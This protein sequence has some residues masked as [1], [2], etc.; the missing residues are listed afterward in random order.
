[1]EQ[2]Q[3]RKGTKQASPKED[4]MGTTRDTV[5][6]LTLAVNL[7][8][9]GIYYFFGVGEEITIGVGAAKKIYYMAGYD[10]E[11]WLLASV[12]CTCLSF[13]IIGI[14]RKK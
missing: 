7:V 1:M 6:Q 9:L 5:V 12:I 10:P 14:S 2:N 4:P 11:M 13:I 3:A 8:T